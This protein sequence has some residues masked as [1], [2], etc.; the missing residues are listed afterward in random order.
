MKKESR[1]ARVRYAVVGL[2]YIS[3]VAV[4]PAFRHAR[5]NSEL[6]ALVSGDAK[7]L[8]K[9]GGQYDVEGRYGYAQFEELLQSGSIDAVYIALPNH[10]H[11]EYAVA[12]AQA[13]IHVLCEKPMAVDEEECEEMIDAARGMNVRLMI[14]YR[15]HFELANLN[16]IQTVRSGRLGDIRAF[17]SIFSMQVAPG[18]IRLGPIERG[19]GTLY[20]IGI[21]C[22][23]AARYLFQAEPI[24]V[25]GCTATREDRRFKESDEMTT[26]I[27]RF[28]EDRLAT[29]TA[30]FG[31][32]SESTYEIL[33]TKGRLRMEN[34]YE[35]VEPMTL[36]IVVDEKKRR[37]RFA[38]RDQFAPE[39]LYFSDCVLQ[40]KNPEPSGRE[41]LAD[42]RIIRAL[43]ESARV[44]LPMKIEPVE[45]GARPT[46]RQEIHRPPVEEP[47]LIGAQSPSGS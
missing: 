30:S 42:V 35:M 4:L 11:R 8:E 45:K 25:F 47:E 16:A 33:G 7:K 37:R 12:A 23:N 31:A 34:A 14:A 19:G 26:A 20:D 5:K 46:I 21:Y 43:Y 44:Q 28:P 15:L 27:L 39:L 1:N 24:E 9:L 6:A 32:A 10:M 36:E 22:I 3:Q 41:G 18:N 2:G 38:K 17:N 40:Q 13:G 29:F